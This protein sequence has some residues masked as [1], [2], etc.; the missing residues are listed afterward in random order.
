MA[1]ESGSQ[2]KSAA[3]TV[4][5]FFVGLALLVL[6]GA[7]CFYFFVGKPAAVPLDRFA[8][9]L[10]QVTQRK[11]EVKGSTVMLEQS[12]VSELAVVERQTQSMIK[13][14]T[15][16]LASDNVLIV[17]GD[18]VVKAGFDLDK[19][20]NLALIDG[21]I[22]GSWPRAEVLSVELV[23]Y[24]VFFS[25]NGTINK[26]QQKDQEGALLLLLAEARKNAQESDIREEAERRLQE[27]L[28]DLGQGDFQLGEQFLP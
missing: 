9:A 7:G 21:R 15:R 26:L 20:A 14:E 12:A 5:A 2:R 16:W 4:L 3:G 27:R 24:E 6:V 8:R 17:R 19:V 18:F 25:Q 23:D 10:E 11:V 1:E 28:E 13:Y 22:G